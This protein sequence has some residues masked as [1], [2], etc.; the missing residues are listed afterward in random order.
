VFETTRDVTVV[1]VRRQVLVIAGVDRTEREISAIEFVLLA[2]ETDR[3]LLPDVSNPAMM[4]FL[5]F[6]LPPGTHD[7]DVQSNL[8]SREV[9]S[10]GSGF[11]ITSPVI[12]GRHSVEFSYIFPYHGN[13][14]SY[15]QPLLQGAEVYQVLVPER[16]APLRAGM[17]DE[18]EPV[19]I[20]GTVYQAWERR[21]IDA[22]Q[23]VALEFLEL[24]EPSL[25]DR[26]QRAITSATLWQ[27]VLPSA[28]GA[29]L[30]VLVLLGVYKGRAGFR[31]ATEALGAPGGDIPLDPDRMVQEIADLDD[32]YERGELID[33]EYRERRQGLKSR[34]LESRQNEPGR[35]QD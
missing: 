17:L 33:A 27:A 15:R 20:Q 11:A 32:R 34:I 21:N 6:S 4:S 2:N 3:T 1:Q 31:A 13:A 16:L 5:R 18:V 10:V 12:P 29:F 7:L 26:F 8:P 14:L 19:R 9:I 30:A 28:L 25:T 35:S 22:G 23:G 24:P